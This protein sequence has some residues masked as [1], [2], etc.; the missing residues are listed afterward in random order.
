MKFTVKRPQTE[1]TGQLELCNIEIVIDTGNADKVE[2][3]MLDEDLNRIEGGQFNAQ[4]FTDHVLSF[5]N[6]HY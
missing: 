3:Y 4:L 6:L 1:R 5:Y 2:L